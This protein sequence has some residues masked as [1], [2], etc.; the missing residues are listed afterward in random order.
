MKKILSLLVVLT[1]AL[2]LAACGSAGTETDVSQ[3][4]QPNSE[5]ETSVR[6]EETSENDVT[7]SERIM[8]LATLKRAIPT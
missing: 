6:E 3:S 5:I 7:Q 4:T 2:G 8:A 1:M